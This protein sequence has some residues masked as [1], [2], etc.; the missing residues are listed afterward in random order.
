MKIGTL[1]TVWRNNE[2]FVTTT[3]TEVQ[4]M[5]GRQVVWVNGISGSYSLDAVR[6][7]LRRNINPFAL[8]AFE[9]AM[10]EI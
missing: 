9:N 2:V 4:K 3:R 1:V 5:C 6:P 10:L 7:I 8:S